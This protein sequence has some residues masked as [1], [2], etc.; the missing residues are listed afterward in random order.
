MRC[1]QKF[2]GPHLSAVA[3]DGGVTVKDSTLST[4]RIVTRGGDVSVTSTEL[5]SPEVV[6]ESYP[7]GM[8]RLQQVA[9][10]YGV[11]GNLHVSSSA[12]NIHI[13]QV[14]GG[15]IAARAGLGD[16]DLLLPVPGF[17]GA[18]DLRAPFGWKSLVV[19][20]LKDRTSSG[21]FC[22]V[23]RE[24]DTSC[25]PCTTLPS[26]PPPTRLRAARRMLCAKYWL[27]AAGFTVAEAVELDDLFVNSTLA[28][29][30]RQ[31]VVDDDSVLTEH[32]LGRVAGAHG[33]FGGQRLL[34]ESGG[35][36]ASV[37]CVLREKVANESIITHWLEQN[38]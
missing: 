36:G 37:R 33:I 29:T 25:T 23:P 19:E 30:D 15:D 5:T 4:C 34:A 7:P 10:G 6:T 16:V 2:K 38:R 14:S 11:R 31:L 17:S 22:P 18:Y 8:D 32:R 1:L 35:R 28:V 27:P 13:D 12:G 9:L 3:S 26:L 24:Q 20:R 21:D